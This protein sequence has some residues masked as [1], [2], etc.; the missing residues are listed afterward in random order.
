MSIRARAPEETYGPALALARH[1]L[2][3]SDPVRLA[4][5]AGVPFARKEGNSGFF[6]VCF[7]GTPYEVSWPEGSANDAADQSGPDVM[8][9]L[10]L[11]HYLLTADATPMADQWVAF[12]S[13]RG[14]MGYEA[15]FRRRADL[16]LAQRFGSDRE[17]FELAAQALGGERLTFGD[18]SFGFRALPSLWLAV[19]LHL[20][21]DE[22]PADASVL[23]DGS[24]NHYLATEDLAVLGGMLAGRLI[25]LARA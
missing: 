9:H 7:L 11:L 8:T 21:D 13:L 6:S 4:H 3:Q 5:L 16:R 12:R 23:F 20:A 1:Q 15:A 19:V 17:A 14:G 22:F 2:V 10:I 25:R 18:A 24:A